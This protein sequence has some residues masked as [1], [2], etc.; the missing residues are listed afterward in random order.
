MTAIDL[1]TQR[2]GYAPTVGMPNLV[3]AIALGTALSLALWWAGHGLAAAIVGVLTAATASAGSYLPLEQ[4]WVGD[5]WLAN[6]QW[7]RTVVAHAGEIRSIALPHPEAGPAYLIFRTIS[8]RALIVDIDQLFRND[9]LALATLGLIQQ[10][11][12]AAIEPEVAAILD[13]LR[14]R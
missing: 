7:R 10:A 5:G 4:V 6:R 3:L 9:A 11:E 13:R 14:T 2:A 1:R 12:N 8:G